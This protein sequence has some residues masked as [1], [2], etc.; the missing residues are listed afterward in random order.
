MASR[1]TEITDFLVTQL[2]EID[3]TVS[4]FNSGYTYTMSGRGVFGKK[5]VCCSL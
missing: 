2:K 4:G 5:I 3:G 1:R